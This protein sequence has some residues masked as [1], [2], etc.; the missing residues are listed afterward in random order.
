MSQYLLKRL[1]WYTEKSTW[2]NSDGIVILPLRNSRSRIWLWSWSHFDIVGLTVMTIN[3]LW[4]RLLEKG[5]L[6]GLAV[7]EYIKPLAGSCQIWQW[8]SQSLTKIWTLQI[9]RGGILDSDSKML[10]K[11]MI[12]TLWQLTGVVI[13]ELLN[14]KQQYITWW[15]L[16]FY[17]KQILKQQD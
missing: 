5:V 16:W 1:G 13:I 17:S 10:Y 2:A 15:Y 4:V 3:E 11:I 12:P 9:Q 14:V 8:N 6:V 7:Y